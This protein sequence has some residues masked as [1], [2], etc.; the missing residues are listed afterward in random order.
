MEKLKCNS[1]RRSLQVEHINTLECQI[2]F[3]LRNTSDPSFYYSD[4]CDLNPDY[5]TA[6]FDEAYLFDSIE[7]VM[8]NDHLGSLAD[9]E[10]AVYPRS[11]TIVQVL[12]V[13][14]AQKI[15]PFPSLH[16]R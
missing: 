13:P 9:K 16:V 14:I 10:I 7:Q 15:Q 5:W 1:L 3:A 12:I 4:G 11:V 2:K 8:S 6:S